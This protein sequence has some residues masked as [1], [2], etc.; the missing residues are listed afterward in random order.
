MTGAMTMETTTTTTSVGAKDASVKEENDTSSLQA[1][2]QHLQ[3]E[4][5]DGKYLTS[6]E[7][8]LLELFQG[9]PLD[10]G[11]SVSGVNGA[12]SGAEGLH[13]LNVAAI[14]ASSGGMLSPAGAATTPGSTKANGGPTL[15]KVSSLPI[16]GGT[17][18]K[19]TDRE[20]VQNFLMQRQNSFG[21]SGSG[22]TP[23]PRGTSGS[24][25]TAAMSNMSALERAKLVMAKKAGK[26]IG[27]RST[28]TGASS[29]SSTAVKRV[30]PLA[31]ILK[32]GT[33]SVVGGVTSSSSSNVA[34]RPRTGKPDLKPGEIRIN[35]GRSSI[36]LP[37]ESF[38]RNE[39][40]DSGTGSALE[41]TL[42]E[43]AFASN[44]TLII[45]ATMPAR[46]MRFCFNISTQTSMMSGAPYP[47]TVLYHFNPRRQRGGMI[48]QNSN[49]D[50]RWGCSQPLAR[51]PITFGEPFTLRLTI[52]PSGFLVFLEEVFQ[53]EFKHRVPIREGE[54]LVLTAPTRD[55]NGN[56]EGVIVHN[57]WW[58][59][60]E[61]PANI[62]TLRRGF[63]N[64]GPGGYQRGG[65]R[66][67]DGGGGYRGGGGGGGGGG[68]PGPGRFHPNPHPFEVYVGNLPP[69]TSREEL[70]FLFQYLG[71]ETVRITARGFGF[72][73]LRSA[74]DMSRAVEDLDGRE[75]NGMKLKV[76]VAMAPK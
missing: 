56:P 22:G 28:S 64:S 31:D 63:P 26:P 68:G 41:I 18:P 23:T 46:S 32:G 36:Q 57:V 74:E 76:S 6:Q 47:G 3:L 61:P 44:N 65:Q 55:E 14:A 51:C 72:V 15:T 9:G 38:L 69:G 5:F 37:V 49:I 11:K 39:D 40:W 17:T 54:N 20:R 43:A 35:G 70:S 8:L 52:V 62:D 27:A 12:A 58:G 30:N 21:V 29:G 7:I 33:G 24:S 19:R 2:Q 34:K 4:A 42:P 48:I 1:L 16:S 25:A 66:G 67:Y 45:H 73:T 71:Y 53:D 59:H 75:F 60:A 50:G 13:A 10:G